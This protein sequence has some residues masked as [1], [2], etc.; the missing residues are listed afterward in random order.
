MKAYRNLS[1]KMK[2]FLMIILIM[3]LI[4]AL[5]F[6]SLYYAYSVYDRQLYD[7]SYRLL[8]LS[9]ATVDMEL[10]KLEGMTLSIIGDRQI[11]TW[12]K[13]LK[14]GETE[15][16]GYITRSLITE[17][18]W[19]HIS[20][21]ERYIQSVQLIDSSGKVSSY[22]E[23]ASF[24]DEKYAR[25]MQEARRGNGAV[26]WLYPD[27][28]D[29]MLIMVRQVRAYDPMSLKEL[30]ILF[31]RINVERLVQDYSGIATKDSD[32]ILKSG[33]ALVYPYRDVPDNLSNVLDPARQGNGYG[34]VEANGEKY[35]LTQKQSA[36]TGWKYYNYVPYSKIF[37]QILLL[38]NMMTALFAL[39]VII[40]VALG[41]SFARHLTKPIRQLILQMKEVQYGDLDSVD[42][43]LAAAPVQQLDEVGLL[44]RTFRLMI[45]RINTLIKENYANQ[46]LIKETE[47]KAL[48]AQINPHFL[49]NS[50]D[51]I[52]W[53]AKKNAQ[54]Q[55]SSMVVSL[56]YLLRSSISLKQNVIPLSDEMEIVNHYITIQT[57]RFRH[58]LDFEQEVP[59][60]FLKAQIPKLTLQPLLENAIQYG[61]ET[62]TA[63]CKIRLYAEER[64]GRLALVVED[65]GPGMEEEHLRS[66]LAGEAKTRSTGI[67]LLNIR[68]R[69]GLAFGE[70]FGI[71]ISAKPGCGTKVTVLL[72]LPGEE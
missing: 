66:V 34:I 23:T 56:G 68:D 55:I 3:L 33:K 21:T 69:I 35:F 46:L 53:L 30:G 22:G 13:E 32:I 40:V 1:I 49:Y 28:E 65:H 42:H 50:L 2:V 5:A 72:P 38:K 60:R 41:L 54:D 17:R 70:Q 9:S 26:R 6:G 62:M 27:E 64:E 52:H 29:P 37:D 71:E 19:T 44:Q 10:K 24:S 57:Y 58:R 45:G 63:P 16:T 14:R 39:A 15:Y 51:S 48:Q 61:V 59:E 11:Q 8:N 4:I 36:Y 25:M 67:G 18:L 20:M 43:N 12:L 7:K 31:L 47:F